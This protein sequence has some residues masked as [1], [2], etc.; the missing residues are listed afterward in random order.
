VTRKSIRL[1]RIG[2]ALAAIV[3]FVWAIAGLWWWA[4]RGMSSDV[5]TA[6]ILTVFPLMFVGAG[7]A[8]FPWGEPEDGEQ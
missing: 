3:G 8:T 5:Q 1:W 2:F 4:L 7:A 6:T